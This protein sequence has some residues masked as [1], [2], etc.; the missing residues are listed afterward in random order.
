MYKLICGYKL[1]D[2]YFRIK[3]KPDFLYKFIFK[4]LLW[5]LIFLQT[6]EKVTLEKKIKNRNYHSK[7]NLYKKLDFDVFRK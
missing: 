4:Y 1:L 6:F 2:F 5:C 3:S 7:M